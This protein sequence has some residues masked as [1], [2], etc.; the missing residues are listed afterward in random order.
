SLA[1]DIERHLR[2]EPVEAS[3]PGAGYRLRKFARRHKRVL[4]M[5]ALLGVM[6]IATIGAIAGTIGWAARDRAARRAKLTG[7]LQLALREAQTLGDQARTLVDDDPHQWQVTLA[8]AQSA[9]KRADALAES[10]RAALEP[11]LLERLAAVKTR[12]EA[13][14]QDRRLL[15]GLD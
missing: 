1:R 15:D 6:L 12:L 3:P 7:A 13:D 14:E 11:A 9:F 10:E 4:A 5:G 8:A 2:D